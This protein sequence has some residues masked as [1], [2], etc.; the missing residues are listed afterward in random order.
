MLVAKGEL[1]M[2]EFMGGIENMVKELVRE[3]GGVSEEKGLN[4]K[5]GSYDAYLI[6][7]GV[8]E[9][10]YTKDGKGVQGFQYQLELEFPQGKQASRKSKSSAHA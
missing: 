8:K 9:Y 7:E 4:G 1:P 10:S 3:Y 5:K 2:Q 6:P